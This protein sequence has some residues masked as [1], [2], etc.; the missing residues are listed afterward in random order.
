MTAFGRPDRDWTSVL[1]ALL[2]GLLVSLVLTDVALLVTTPGGGLA[3]SVRLLLA[4][5]AF[6][7]VVLGLALGTVHTP[8]YAVGTVVT[9]P[10]A[11]LYAYTGLLLPWTQLSFYLGQVGVE[12]LLGMPVVGEPLALALFGGFTL[13]QET[14]RASF[15]FHYVT[16][17]LGV[18]GAALV[19]TSLLRRRS[20][21]RPAS[22]DG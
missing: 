3:A 18:A 4:L 1:E 19:A 15:R 14:L 13:T 5:G 16:V 6:G 2:L 7:V 21:G 9:I 17:G 10:L 12:L 20:S 8:G 22:P 11:V